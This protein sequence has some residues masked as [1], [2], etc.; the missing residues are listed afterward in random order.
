MDQAVNP[1]LCTNALMNRLDVRNYNFLGVK[2][3]L[4]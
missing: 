1:K 2:Q 4:K 3:E